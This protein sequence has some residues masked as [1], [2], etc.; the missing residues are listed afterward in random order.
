MKIRSLIRQP[1]GKIKNY[2][3][4]F[5]LT[6]GIVASTIIATAVVGILALLASSLRI[7]QLSESQLVASMLAQEGVEVARAI[8]DANWIA[9]S[10]RPW[11]AGFSNGDYQV[12][13]NSTAFL[14]FSGS[15]LR[16]DTTT[17]RYQYDTGTNTEFVRRIII[18][19]LSV[20]ELRVISRVSWT[21][22]NIPFSI[23]VEAHLFNWF[24]P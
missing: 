18:T 16:F 2:T 24:I 19:N 1:A 4:G 7:A 23:D 14:P 12:E 15:P 20:D 10:P 21:V 13:Y 11:N 8:R 9:D 5:M 6:E 3:A 17:R 22:R